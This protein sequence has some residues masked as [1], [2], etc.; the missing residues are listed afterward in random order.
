MSG[1]VT[2]RVYTNKRNVDI[3]G[4]KDKSGLAS[5]I[6][7][8]MLK[9]IIAR[10]VKYNVI[11]KT[12]NT[13]INPPYL[14]TSDKTIVNE[15]ESIT[16]TVTT[17]NALDGTM[18]YWDVNHI[19]TTNN[20][21]SGNVSNG[22]IIIIDNTGTFNVTIKNDDVLENDETFKVNLR[23]DNSSGP[24][25][26]ISDVITIRNKY[27]LIPDK[28]IVTEGDSI[29]FTVT[30]SN[31][32]NT[33]LYWDVLNINT[34]VN[35]F[36]GNITSGSVVINNSTGT[37]SI[38]IANDIILNNDKM[39]KVNLRTDNSSGPIVAI[40]DV[41]SIKNKYQLTSQTTGI[42]EGETLT[43]NVTTIDIV[44][45]TTLY[46]DIS[47]VTTST[48]DFTGNTN[49]TITINNNTGSFTITTNNDL[50][51]ENEEIFRVNL[52][53]DNSSGPIVA[54]SN[55]ISI[56]YKLT[57]EIGYVTLINS[58][59][60]NDAGD[61]FAFSEPDRSIIYTKINDVWTIEKEYFNINIATSISLNSAGNK[62]L[63]CMVRSNI[64]QN[65]IYIYEKING[66]WLTVP[67]LET[68]ITIPI[69]KIPRC[70]FN[71]INDNFVLFYFSSSSNLPTI[72]V[73]IKNGNNY[74]LVIEKVANN[75]YD[76][77]TAQNLSVAFH[78][79]LILIGASNVYLATLYE[80]TNVNNS[81]N[82][83]II[84]SFPYNGNV[85][86]NKQGTSILVGNNIF[87]K[88][89]DIW[90]SVPTFTFNSETY[91]NSID[92]SGETVIFC[93]LDKP[94]TI[95]KKYDGLWSNTPYRVLNPLTVPLQPPNQALVSINA[96]SNVVLTA[97]GAI[98]QPFDIEGTSI[99]IYE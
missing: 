81:W 77:N 28:T 16:F 39:F 33:T 36:S 97:C 90:N 20:D 40:S 56:V 88:D 64:F 82:L 71:N 38:T 34:T 80:L 6:G 31:N 62:I 72:A 8:T 4:G 19:S 25:V 95:Y 76:I 12:T 59:D 23:K 79:N 69:S 2:K 17:T 85:N 73:F 84:K 55:P 49:G 21:F 7:P 48:N 58:I 32:P 70:S 54:I 46:W 53:T 66:M 65:N 26:A 3:G 15:S 43:F 68:L 29:T 99:F 24:I 35:D 92:S 94:F 52:R 18:F 22:T 61:T 5:S 1:Y 74:N 13:N 47:N 96:L 44:D 37:F 50:L 75:I 91:S 45:N 63:I 9:P 57:K 10:R 83:N 89:N 78:D 51:V 86:I 98:I 93:G 42:G 30:T 87:E 14:I 60:M 11:N 67:S 27:Q 41:I